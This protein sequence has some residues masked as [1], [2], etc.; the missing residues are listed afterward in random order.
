MAQSLDQCMGL[1]RPQVAVP[2]AGKDHV[3][4]LD[5]A[6]REVVQP[7]G[8]EVTRQATE[9][10]TQAQ[11]LADQLRAEAQAD[12]EAMRAELARNRDINDTLVR[13]AAEKQAQAE[14]AA[15]AA[16]ARLDEA[17]RDAVTLLE[18]ASAQAGLI[19]RTAE[20]TS[21][22][23]VALARSEAERILTDAKNTSDALHEN[24][25]R[26]VEEVK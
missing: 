2:L 23:V 14:A 10:L 20:R 16:T 26:A 9:I 15:T 25:A 13:T 1:G 22:E 4:V 3:R 7:A 21:A 5:H 18:D 12:A 19:T 6:A 8:I 11:N 24:A 17:R